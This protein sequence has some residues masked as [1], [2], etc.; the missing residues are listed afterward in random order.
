MPSKKNSLV[1]VVAVEEL[2]YFPFP[3]EVERRRYFI[4]KNGS[5]Y[6]LLSRECT[7]M[8]G[9]VQQKNEKLEC[10]I[11]GW[12]F[13]STSGEGL[14]HSSHLERID[15]V[16]KDGQ[17]WM[18]SQEVQ[19]TQSTRKSASIPD[20]TMT[21]VAH[22]CI[23]IEYKNFHVLTDPWLD[24]PAYF[25]SWV[26]YPPPHAKAEQ[27]NPD[28]IIISHEHSDHFHEPTL[29]NFEKNI[30]IYIPDFPNQRLQQRLQ[31]L[32]FTQIN[33]MP[34]GVRTKVGK[35][36]Y[37]TFYEPGSTWNDA[38]QLLEIG[39]FRFLN[40]NDAGINRRIVD[41]VAPVDM[42][43]I[44]FSP[45]ASSYPLTWTHISDER[46]TEIMENGRLGMFEMLKS[47]IPLYQAK[48]LLPYSSFWKLGHP[49][50]RKY[51]RMMR[52]NTL[53]DVTT[54]LSDTNIRVVDLFPGDAWKAHQD[55]IAH[56]M[57]DR[58]LFYKKEFIEKY[59]DA[60]YKSNHIADYFPQKLGLSREEVINYFLRLNDVPEI[61]FCEDMIFSIETLTLDE[62]IEDTYIFSVKN[63]QLKHLKKAPKKTINLTMQILTPIFEK[64]ISENLSWDEAHIGYW[65]KF[66]RQP[67]IYHTGFW[68][69][70]QAPYFK[71]NIEMPR[72]QKSGNFLVTADTT[73]IGDILEQL[74]NHA[75]KVMRR[76]GFYCS[77]CFRST[78]D[79]LAIGA[80]VHGIKDGAL[81]ALVKELNALQS[82]S[83]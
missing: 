59:L 61:V 20:F 9:E 23:D 71:K 10:P 73:P 36:I 52:Y 31:E 46:K 2:T 22:G 57:K 81:S 69:L 62:N 79:T 37:T 35:G 67:D 17:L 50:H 33:P 15:L 66:H 49:E 56:K 12:E 80:R 65:C 3:V 7:H 47:L 48:Y 24:G 77:G 74:G 34:F 78:H 53:A 25:G 13:D 64:I 1:R 4:T 76:Y 68:R 28:A 82:Q 8:G 5:G 45:G 51:L 83:H 72:A 54:A 43:G 11:H 70:I 38:I 55:K 6:Q 60:Q 32:G 42:I 40:L 16:T 41:L 44:A 14:N 29:R 26:Q 58:E 39:N 30:P 27:L 18:P 19:V 21:L 63:G 75:E